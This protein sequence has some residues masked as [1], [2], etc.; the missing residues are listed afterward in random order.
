MSRQHRHHRFQSANLFSKRVLLPILVGFLVSIAVVILWQRLLI[1]EKTDIKQLIQQQAIAIKTELTSELNSHILALER[2]QRR[3][4]IHGVIPQ[5]QWEA[6]AA[7]YVKDYKGYQAIERVDS[8]LQVRWIVP[9]T[10]NEAAQNLDLSQELQLGVAQEVTGDRHQTTLT[11]T[12]NLIQGGKGFLVYL[13]LFVENK[14]DG[15]I[16]GVFQYQALLDAVVR[17]PK[18]Y[19]IRVFDNQELIYS[20]DSSPSA[21]KQKSE[22]H[23]SS[24]PPSLVQTRFIASLPT[25]KSPWQQEVSLDLYGIKWQ[26]QIY[27]TPELLTN[28][29]SPL[30]TVILVA[31]LLIAGTLTLSI[32]F[33][34]ATKLS[35]QQIAA[36]NQELAQKIFDLEQTEIALRASENRLRQLLETVKVIPWEVDL[37]TRQFTY[38]GPQAEALLNYPIEEW[39]QENFLLDRI[40]PHDREKALKFCSEVTA[41]GENHE[42]E[43]R[44]LTADGRIIWLRDIVSVVHQAETP[45]TL[46]GFMFDISDLKLVEETL[47]LRERALAASNNGIMIADA[48]LANHPVIYVNSAFEKITGYSA[49]E[50]IGRNCRFLQGTD[51]E[52]QPAI[53]ELHSAIETGKNC[54]VVLRNYRKDGSLFWNELSI[55]PIHDENGQLTH[56]IGIQNDISDRA[57]A[58]AALR[59]KEQRWQLALQ[60]NNDGIWDWNVKTNEVFF[61]PRWKEMLG[62]QDHEICHH[63]EEWAKRVH[64]D[65][66]ETVVLLIQDHFAK[67]TPFYI[68]EHRVQC[69]NGSYKWILDRGQALW[70]E[71]G[72][73]VR[74]VGSYTDITIGKQ[75]EEALKESEARFRT[76]ADSVPVLLWVADTNALRTFF[77]QTWLNFTGRALE[78][79]LG[80]GWAEGIHPED[81]QNCLDTYFSAFAARQPFEMEFQLRRGDKEYRWILDTG[82]PRFNSDGSFAGF[83]GSCVDISERQAALRDRKQAEASLR[84]QALTFE[85]MYDGVIITDIKGN[86]IDWNPAAERM[87]GYTK[88]EVL[89]KTPSILHK[90]E[91][92]AILNS[93]I[94]QEISQQERWSGE[95]VFV[96]KDG[97]ESICETTILPLQ[98][99]QG[100]TFATIGVHHDITE[101][102]RA[103]VALRESEERWQL[104]IEANQDAIWDWNIITNQT[105][106]STKWAELV[107][108]PAYQP[109]SNDDWFNHI[110]PDDYDWVMA[111][112]QEYL[113]RQIPH[114][115]V[116]YRLCCHDGSYKWV[117]V[118]AIAQWDEQGN[119]VRLV[120]ATKDITERVQAQ[121]A[122]RRQLHRTLLLEQITQKIRQSLD[123][124]EIFET[125]ATQI[126]RAFGV[127]RCLIHSYISDPTP[128]IPIVAEYVVSGYCSMLNMEIPMADNPY[129]QQLM[130][131]DTA[132]SNDQLLCVYISPELCVDAL[133]PA[134]DPSC[135]EIR[136]KSMLS[137]RTSYQGQPN[138]AISLHQCS[139]IRQ[140]TPDEIEL[141]EAVAI[142]LGIALVQA[143][144]LE[145]ETQQREELTWKNFA[146]EQAKRQAEAANRAKSEFLAMMSHEIRTPMNAVIGMT[147][148]LLD[149]NLTPQQQDFVETVRTSGDALLTIINDILDFS[150]IESG[151]LELEKQPFDLRDCVEQVIDL[152]APKAAQ[153]D[154]ELAYLIYP[155]VPV[156]IVGDLAR[157]RQVLMNLLNNAIKFTK[158]GEVVLS[159]RAQKLTSKRAENFTEILF[160][161]EDTG[162]GIAPEKMERLFQPF[163]QADASMTR[164]YGGTGLGL[165]I[166]KRL[167]DMMG[168]SLWVESQGCV[169]GNPS[170]KWQGEKLVSSTHLCCGSTFYF[171]ITVPVAANP[172]SGEF[173][174]SLAQ[175]VGKRLLIVDNN[176]TSQKILKMQAEFWQMQT[177]TA[178][179]GEAA[180]ALLNKGMQVDIAIVDMQMPKMHGLTLAR[181]IRKHPGYEN[182]PIVILTS[183]G[184]SD[185]YHFDDVEFATCLSKP[186]KQSQLYDILAHTLGNQPLRAS[187]SRPHPS[188]VGSH[189]LEQQSLRILLAEDTIMNQKV[190]L[191]MLKKIGYQA[192]V[193]ANGLEVLEALRQQLY[194]VVLMDINMPEMDG[195]EASRRICQGWEVSSR[196]Y[197]IAMTANAMR[198]DRESCLAAGMDDYISKPVQIKELTQALSKCRPRI[199]AKLF[200]GGKLVSE[201]VHN[202]PTEAQNSAKSQTK[203]LEIATIDTKI[204]QSLCN[205]VGGKVAF[206]ELLE[207]YLIETPKLIQNIN[208]AVTN[209]DA[210]TLWKTAHNLKSSSASVGATS[211]SQLCKQLETQG[212]S[213]NL[214]GIGEIC[215]RLHNEF[216]QVKTALQTELE[217]E[218]K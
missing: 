50:V 37:K 87:F 10:G 190:A 13:P 93:Q 186:V 204:L 17:I 19:K 177:W 92:A 70:D 46:R 114:Y 38:V 121:E 197:I 83:I 25:Q 53:N 9:L 209:Q 45:S 199:S 127:S 213:N 216:E 82:V 195:L 134:T 72:N 27:P 1:E 123:T 2:M 157:L 169:G 59:E 160:T 187:V 215:L 110:H 168:G 126:G 141:L 162:I 189:G 58:E 176:P 76:M 67:K 142:Q 14:F 61:S 23:T 175:L 6:E 161:I 52:Q 137:V 130:A 74:M 95:I 31:G 218:V 49:D 184:K 163:T 159:V 97:K 62:Y 111:I 77:N 135:Q 201:S 173:Y 11:R 85:N 28:L 48:R 155:Q 4:E 211:L 124:K 144:L 41:R 89:G 191:L 112:K 179:S 86:I 103:E 217:K 132:M 79:E 194:D 22:E 16:L 153:K 196:P 63:A 64:P 84:R 113:T 21:S 55:S 99:E 182:I 39:Y 185:N 29:R 188:G 98:D 206:A 18:G 164:Q 15:F 34:Q 154:I 24:T 66:I 205:M 120:G 149:T 47:R 30:P 109:I 44:M 198:G 129:I 78:Q 33:A 125:A 214:Q 151:K 143:H 68:S 116:E 180:L 91:Q 26:I 133:L 54:K 203:N 105:F 183:L 131:Q 101:R 202:K 75:M 128:R 51:T 150:K 148:L 181:K 60:G 156:Q 152:L 208:A 12:I 43:Y 172:D 65:D 167:S 145:Q 40:H 122:L 107:G 80:H 106:Y 147:E 117:L 36:I 138:G 115:I 71:R 192:D 56:F 5:K 166:S 88:A 174:T 90:P 96:R 100:E 108:K 42:F 102:K 7:D 35:N 171:T 158:E 193:V 140:W 57:F 210:Q 73:A 119:P 170:A 212:R 139:Y 81:L 118:H 104:V 69:K 200:D 207:C 178:N 8:S 94:L 32:Y 146:L 20:N 3:W 136:L 165:V